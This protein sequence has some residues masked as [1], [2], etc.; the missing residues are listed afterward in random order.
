[1]I[2]AK[3]RSPAPLRH[4]PRGMDQAEEAAL[5]A[6]HQ[7]RVE[8]FAEDL[9][10]PYVDALPSEPEKANQKEFNDPIW[11]TLYLR[12]EEVVVLDSPVLQRLR[13]VKQLGVVHYVYPAA[14]H[15]RLEHSLGVVHQ[16]QRMITSLNDRGLEAEEAPPA[17]QHS[18][19]SVD[20]EAAMRM[21]ALCHDIGHGFMSHVSEYALETDRQCENLQL[22]FQN[23]N[24]R[25]AKPQLS[26]LAA[27]YMVG[28]K[29]FHDLLAKAFAVS[30][31]PQPPDLAARMQ[32]LIM[33]R[34]VDEKLLLVH[35]FISGPFDA[36]KL[37]YYARDSFM[38]GIPN[39]TDIPRLI[40]KLRA[41]HVDRERLPTGLKKGVKDRQQGY[42][43]TGI[44]TSGG[45]TLDEIAL[46]RTLL[47]DKVYR[48]QKVRAIES[49]VFRVVQLLAEMAQVHP[50]MLPY[51]LS[52]DD[53]LSLDRA[54]IRDIIGREI[55]GGDEERIAI[56]VDLSKRLRERRLFSRGFAFASVMTEDDYRHDPGQTKGLQSFLRDATTKPDAFMAKVLE[57]VVEIA[58]VTGV[59]LPMPVEQLDS[60][61]RLSPPKTS[62]RQ[63]NSDTGHAQLI[64]SDGRVTPFSEDAAETTPWTDAYVATRDLGHVFCPQELAPIVYIA[65]QAALLDAYG[66]RIPRTMLHYAKQSETGIEKIRLKLEEQGWFDERA[67]ELRPLPKALKEAAAPDRIEMIAGQLR[68][69]WGPSRTSSAN[70]SV[71]AAGT[72]GAAQITAFVRQFAQGG[73]D[74]VDPA[75]SALS[76]LR[77]IGRD[78]TKRAVTEFIAAHPEFAG[79]ACAPLGAGKDSS[80]VLTYFVNDVAEEADLTIKTVEGAVASGRPIIFVDDF[81]GTGAQAVD[82]I[83]SWLGVERTE[84]IE[85]GREPLA[86]DVGALLRQRRLGFVFAAAVGP[87]EANLR[88]KLDAEGLNVE[89][90]VGVGVEKLPRLD[91]AVDADQLTAFTEF[92]RKVGDRVLMN[93]DRKERSVE[94]RRDK[95]LG[96]GDQGLLVASAFNTPT[97]SLTLLWAGSQDWVP[98]LPRRTKR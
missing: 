57:L 38:C 11:G 83:Q 88:A 85:E 4:Y 70:E 77:I 90:H 78:D 89:V 66:V 5:L 97:A 50:A 69:Y 6:D 24:Q 60:Y 39:V 2:S 19:V 23:Q 26:E 25:P 91:S 56:I 61:V 43:V 18:V 7:T 28:S 73:S 54:R 17:S 46:A 1:L 62:K 79:A 52:D 63:Q 49:M 8:E 45:R 16:V 3:W 32:A 14:T 92:A 20:L 82:I 64:E 55:N 95:T 44:A 93:Y 30:R 98:L 81:I 72:V 40:Q 10:R 48:H 53:A 35:E 68:G 41:A 34:A 96:Y 22:A 58:D 9:L 13:R 33:G 75:L 84:G 15:S 67:I 74:L 31:I 59:A 29:V 76:H 42:V 71:G 37:D 87:G 51:Q 80:N 27:Y 36:D 12:P 47:Y 21:A 94:W 86:E 65:T